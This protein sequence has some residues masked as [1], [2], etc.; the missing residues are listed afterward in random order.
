MGVEIQYK[1]DC[2]NLVVMNHTPRPY[3]F[4]I[5]GARSWVTIEPGMGVL[6]W[7]DK[8]WT[9]AEAW[10]SYVVKVPPAFPDEPIT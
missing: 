10:V 6:A 2:L 7:M 3:L 5:P 8:G 9:R 1:R 4:R